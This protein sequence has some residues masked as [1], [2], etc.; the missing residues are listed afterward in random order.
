MNQSKDKISIKVPQIFQNN[1]LSDMINS[2]NQN[3]E[4]SKSENENNENLNI[5]FN[6]KNNQINQDENNIENILREEYPQYFMKEFKTPI[7]FKY[8]KNPFQENT[9]KNNENII[10]EFLNKYEVNFNYKELLKKINLVKWL[11]SYTI[12]TGNQIKSISLVL[13][14]FKNNFSFNS[15]STVCEVKEVIIID[16]LQVLTVIDIKLNKKKIILTNIENKNNFLIDDYFLR[17]GDIILFR[18]QN[19]DEKYLKLNVK[20][21]QKLC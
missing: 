18:M 9:K 1:L 21:I 20:E 19:K 2:F 8:S 17:E 5:D 12:L 10:L 6:L 4:N 11:Y 3:N 14:Y 16:C 13:N 7:E 15:N